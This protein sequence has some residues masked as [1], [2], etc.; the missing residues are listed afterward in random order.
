MPG[1]ILRKAGISIGIFILWCIILFIFLYP[2]KS[3]L[4]NA[5]SVVIFLS[6]TLFLSLTVGVIAVV[7]RLLKLL[8]LTSFFYIFSGTLNIGMG[9]YG[10]ILFLL[11]RMK[12]SNYMQLYAYSLLIGLVI[13]TD[14][15]L[16]KKMRSLTNVDSNESK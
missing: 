3:G 16:T 4:G 12:E 14:L 5:F 8:K 10:L 7:L 1:I 11:H 9:V 2:D 6:F 13:M 15:I